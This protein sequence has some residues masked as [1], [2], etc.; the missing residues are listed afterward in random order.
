MQGK[1]NAALYYSEQHGVSAQELLQYDNPQAMEL[2]A[3]QKSEIKGLKDKVA[4]L[5]KSGVPAQTMD[6]NTAS[7]AMGTSQERL[8]DSALNKAPGER[9]QAEQEA[10]ARMAGG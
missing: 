4:N 9:T 10:L 8:V 3:L 1:M 5:Q 2:A 6:S 7:P